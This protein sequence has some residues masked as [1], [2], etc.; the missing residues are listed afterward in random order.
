MYRPRLAFTLVELLIALVVIAI[1][2]ALMLPAVKRLRES[3]ARTQCAHQLRQLGSA[4]HDY[5]AVNKSLPP[6]CL[7]SSMYGPGPIVMLLAHLD[8]DGFGGASGVAGGMASSDV[9]GAMRIP[10]LACPSD[11]HDPRDYLIGWT[12]YHSNYGTWVKIRGWDGAYGPNFDVGGA[13]RTGGLQFRDIGDGLSHTAAFAEVANGRGRDAAAEPDPRVDCFEFGTLNATTLSQARERLLA[14][15]W[16]TAN[17]AHPAS[18]DSPWR[19]RGYPWREG[20][21]WRTGYNHLL[22]PNKAC[23]RCNNDWWQLV[24]PASSFHPG[25]VNVLMADGAVR[26]VGD[27]IDPD[28]WTAAGSRDGEE[29]GAI[30]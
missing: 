20:T 11:R 15:D 8:R 16:R 29:T 10:L 24:S 1:V 14:K 5:H 28:V 6:A 19:W 22:P 21:I 17:F 7:T 18:G 2:V 13:R 12:N 23:W 27:D 25:G 30:H 9:A 4:M 3:A 26:F